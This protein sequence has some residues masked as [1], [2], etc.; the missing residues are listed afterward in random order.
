MS[1]LPERFVG[2]EGCSNFRDLGGWNTRTGGRVRRGLVFRSDALHELS[3]DDVRHL[4]ERIGIRDVIDL[5]TPVEVESDVHGALIH[6][7]VRYHHVSLLPPERSEARELAPGESFQLDR[8]YLGILR[9]GGRGVARVLELLAGSGEPAVFHCAAG[10]DRTGVIAALL[11][12][13]LEVDDEQIAQD[14]A[15]T[16]HGLAGIAGRL[17][18]SQGYTDLWQD[19]PPESL[20]ARADTI[21]VWLARVRAE[22]GSAEGYARAAGLAPD[23]LARL[24]GRLVE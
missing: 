6:P 8:F 21:H 18:R 24:R 11:L 14:Y 1:D 2:L 20:H 17:R 3:A 19:L 16:Q 5:R 7:P 9:R 22:W 10:K 4:R 12:A 15:L 13:L 23:A